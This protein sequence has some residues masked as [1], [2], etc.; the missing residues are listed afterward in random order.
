MKLIFVVSFLAAIATASSAAAQ[1]PAKRGPTV[2]DRIRRI[3][4]GLAPH[5]AIKGAPPVRMKLADRMRHYR[6]PGVSVAVINDGRVEW[7][8]GWGLREIGRPDPVTAET[9]FNAGSVS[10]PVGAM[11]A[12]R[13]VQDGKLALTGDVNGRL[14]SWNA[15]AFLVDNERLPDP[16]NPRIERDA[17]GLPTS[18]RVVAPG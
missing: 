1:A 18:V 2:E 16:L 14:T 6:A 13:L 7:A 8:R 15:Y 9:L 11:G 4:N 5:V 3:E 10:K 17:E 12:L